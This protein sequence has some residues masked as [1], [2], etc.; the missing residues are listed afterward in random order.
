[1]GRGRGG[2][3]VFGRK[4]D[5]FFMGIMGEEW[6]VNGGVGVIYGRNSFDSVKRESVML[7]F[8]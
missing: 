8:F 1:M 3:E 2:G 7:W 5:F 6:G 4:N